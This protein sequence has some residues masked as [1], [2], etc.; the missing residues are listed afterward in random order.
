MKLQFYLRYY[1]KFG[2]SLWIG[3]NTDELGNDDPSKTLPLDYLNEE[4]WYCSIEIKRKD[5]SKNIFCNH[6]PA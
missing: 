4:F 1:T 5:L 3:G 6:P 2:Q